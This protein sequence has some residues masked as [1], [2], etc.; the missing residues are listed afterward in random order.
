M[1][2]RP[3]TVELTRVSMTKGT[4]APPDN[5]AEKSIVKALW[6]SFSPKTLD[7]IS[8]HTGHSTKTL[9]KGEA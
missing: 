1:K 4:V 2:K 9:T 7:A 6:A 5:K 8:A 3:D